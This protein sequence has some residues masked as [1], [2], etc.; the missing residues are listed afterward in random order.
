MASSSVTLGASV[1]SYVDAA[2]ATRIGQPDRLIHLFGIAH[3]EIGQNLADS[4]LERS[5]KQ[6]PQPADQ[7]P[8]RCPD[9]VLDQ[10]T[11]AVH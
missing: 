9:S 8:T 3:I 4:L 7:E 5:L 11:R 6:E 1:A 2:Q 10:L